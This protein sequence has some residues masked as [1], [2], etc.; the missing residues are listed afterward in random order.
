MFLR[1]SIVGVGVMSG[2]SVDGIDVAV[3]RFPSG[4]VGS[5]KVLRFAELPFPP[6][7]AARVKEAMERGSS[8]QLC[9]LDAEL[10]RLFGD[11]VASVLAEQNESPLFVAS[12]GQTLW[13]APA[14][15][16]TLQL[17]DASSILQ[18]APS[19]VQFVVSNFRPADVAAGGQGAPLVPFFDSW[20][21]GSS[22]DELCLANVG[23]IANVTLLGANLPVIGFDCGPGNVVADSLCLQLLQLPCDVDGSVSSKGKVVPQVLAEMFRLAKPFLS[24]ESGPRSTGRELFGAQFARQIVSAFPSERP[25]DLVCTAVEF[26]AVTMWNAIRRS[27]RRPATL[28]VAGGGS[29]NPT[30]MSRL[31]GPCCCRVFVVF[32][33]DDCQVLGTAARLFNKTNGSKLL[34]KG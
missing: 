23:G 31:R 11:A 21:W 8:E 9:V 20:A 19:S 18:R 28:V 32:F 12:H 17:G 5:C 29:R 25:E 4:N 27:Q 34:W 3:V 22:P 10:G 7:L 15:R 13:H 14:A 30:L 26:T 16:A 33:F 1:D 6:A 2:T 24:Q